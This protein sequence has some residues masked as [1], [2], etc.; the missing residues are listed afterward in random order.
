MKKPQ[1]KK[2]KTLST[3][4]SMAAASTEKKSSQ[5]GS[6]LKFNADSYDLIARFTSKT[7]ISYAPNPKTP[8]SKS[9]DRYKLYEK[10][11]TVGDALKHCKPADLLWEYERGYLKVLGGPMADV[12]ACMAPP[13]KDPTIQILAKFR[14]PNGC[15]IKMDPAIRGKLTSLA[16]QF[17]MDLD[18]IHEEAGKQC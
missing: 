18:A 15:S 9:F 7:K 2:A 16:K 14:G 6:G 11:K 13:S 3:I 10:A 5:R 17:G 8:G 4:R 12:P 1:V